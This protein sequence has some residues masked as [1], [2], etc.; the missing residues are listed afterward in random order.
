MNKKRVVIGMSGASGAPY[1]L[2]VVQTLLGRGDTVH[3]ILTEAAW[4][5]L[6]E[7]HGWVLSNREAFLQSQFKG[8]PG[9]LIYH[10]LK[11]IGASIASGSF[12]CDAMVVIPCS[13]GTLAKLAHGLSTNLLERT[14]DV[15]LKE[16]RKLVIVPREMPLSA[17][18]LENMLKLAQN[19][20][21]ILPAMPAFYHEP[22]SVEDMVRF[23]AGKVLD[24]IEVEHQL[25]K[26]WEGG[27]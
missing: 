18:H 27:K 19:G 25:Y 22:R 16:K 4:R 24:S 10:P 15:M 6:K 17:I 7:E 23:V 2:Q 14:V 9:E 3:I 13:M 12:Q 20:A 11:D 21:H 26:R 1:A 5:V 8:L